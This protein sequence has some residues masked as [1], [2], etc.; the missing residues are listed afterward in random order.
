MIEHL[1]G[2]NVDDGWALVEGIVW[3][4]DDGDLLTNEVAVESRPRVAHAARE[5]SHMVEAF[6]IADLIV[7]SIFAKHDIGLGVFF[8]LEHLRSESLGCD[9]VGHVVLQQNMI[10]LHDG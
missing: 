10:L 5:L 4:F 7:G 6:K 3:P 1:E 9:H 8:G 2:T